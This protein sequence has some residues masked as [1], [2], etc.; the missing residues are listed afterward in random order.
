MDE[1]PTAPAVLHAHA[2]VAALPLLLALLTFA[3]LAPLSQFRKLLR[4]V[5]DIGDAFLLLRGRFA[6]GPAF[7]YFRSL[8]VAFLDPVPQLIDGQPRAV[9]S[10]RDSGEPGTVAVLIREN[11]PACLDQPSG[12][13]KPFPVARHLR[14]VD[15]Q[16]AGHAPVRV[17]GR[18]MAFRRREVVPDGLP[19]SD[20]AVVILD[21]FREHVPVFVGNFRMFS[22]SAHA[23]DEVVITF[24]EK[25][26]QIGLRGAV[27]QLVPIPLQCVVERPPVRL[28]VLY[29][30]RLVRAFMIQPFLYPLCLCRLECGGAPIRAGAGMKRL[31]SVEVLLADAG[32]L[33]EQPVEGPRLGAEWSGLL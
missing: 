29:P 16:K 20:L 13:P 14:Q 17:A 8:D 2:P 23:A 26:R 6:L 30:G 32:T 18:H 11:G 19:C 25:Q 28:D 15:I 7:I 3:L 5:E 1:I 4:I 12:F 10:G 27:D 33:G 22:K 31:E 9:L 21:Q 24:Y